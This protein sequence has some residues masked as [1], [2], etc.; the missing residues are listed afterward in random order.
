[1]LSLQNASFV[2]DKTDLNNEN[3]EVDFNNGEIIEFK[4]TEITFDVRKVK[5]LFFM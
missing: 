4:L 1:M 5:H 3:E 2:F